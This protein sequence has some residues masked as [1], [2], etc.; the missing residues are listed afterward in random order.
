MRYA[1]YDP[2]TGEVIAHFAGPQHAVETVELPDDHPDILAYK[3]RVQASIHPSVDLHVAGTVRRSPYARGLTRILAERFGITEREL[4]EAI[5][6]AAK[7]EPLRPL[8]E[9]PA[10]EPT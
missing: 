1:Q 9:P 2:V 7:R 5:I 4:L 6:E 3:A 8:D 10:T